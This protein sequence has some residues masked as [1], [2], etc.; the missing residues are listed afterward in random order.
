MLY[1]YM[2]THA[3]T[4]THAFLKN[5]GGGHE[6]WRRNFFRN[7]HVHG[8]SS[9]LTR[10]SKNPLLHAERRPLA[11]TLPAT[12]APTQQMQTNTFF[13]HQKRFFV[14]TNAN[15]LVHHRPCAALYHCQSPTIQT[16]PGRTRPK[17]SEQTRVS[18]EFSL[19]LRFSL[20]PSFPPS[21]LPS[22]PPSL[23]LPPFLPP[24][25]PCARSLSRSLF[26]LLSL[27]LSLSLSTST[28]TF[29]YLSLSFSI[30]L[31]LS[32]HPAPFCRP[33]QQARL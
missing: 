18:G 31:S 28:S 1:T 22:L 8:Q 17:R 21:L 2:F 4:N 5:P 9:F 10:H 27:S 14:A 13:Q 16:N 15:V 6:G 32:L 3:S 19:S 30:S 33:A 23:P 29:F 26:F 7:F 11:P 25:L 12:P 20:P 24:S